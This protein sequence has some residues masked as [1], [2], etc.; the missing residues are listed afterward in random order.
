MKCTIECY[1]ENGRLVEY[2]GT[3]TEEGAERFVKD[4][5]YV[6]SEIKVTHGLKPNCTKVLEDY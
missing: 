5:Q 4:F 3:H 6:Y 1:D 2:V